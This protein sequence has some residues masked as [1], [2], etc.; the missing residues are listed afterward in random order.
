MT[1]RRKFGTNL[2]AVSCKKVNIDLLDS[3]HLAVHL[4]AKN[5]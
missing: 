2:T 5:V 3:E 4:L 1:I